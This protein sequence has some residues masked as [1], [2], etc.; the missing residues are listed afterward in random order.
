MEHASREGEDSIRTLAGDLPQ[1]IGRRV[2]IQGWMHNLRKM[3]AVNFLTLR[4][5]SGMAQV[6]LEQEELEALSGLQMETV[7][8]IDGTVR[9]E[10]RA[11][12]G[13]ELAGS[14]IQILAPVTD[15][16]PFEINK[17]V[18]KPSLD[19]FLNN[20]PV[21]LRFPKRRSVFRVYADLIAGFRE[22]LIPRGF[23]EIHTPKLAGS[24]TEGGANVFA[25]E[26]FGKQAYLA[27]SPQLYKQIMV[28]VFER[29]F[30]IGPVFRAEEHYTV[31]HLNE[32]NSLDVEV[33]FIEGQ[34][35]IMDLLI[36]VVECMVL[37]AFERHPE[38]AASLELIRPRFGDVPRI[39]FREAQRLILER[40]GVDQSTEPDLSPQDER[41]IGEWA[42]ETHDTDFV[43]VTHYP[44]AKRA[45]YT[46]PDPTDPA[47]SLSFDLLYKGQ[48]LVSGSQRINRYDQLVQ[49]MRDRNIDPEPFAGYLQAF[50]FGMPPEG[51]F[52]IGS[53]RLLMRLTGAENLRETTL[54]PRD[55][56]R[57]TP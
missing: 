36:E 15:V 9:A 18:L 34:D 31:R 44:T 30:E 37:A 55:V 8:S 1:N 42:S 27:Q 6:F 17:K 14:T 2:V 39:T 28:G 38:D 46:M 25:M 56:N 7:L 43:F 10:E 32:F 49:A 12:G 5:R 29:V 24:A 52:A 50:R 45:F 16:L 57:L 33:G 19:V 22:Y 3:G 40:H 20:A 47:H 48:E 51:G 13:V 41:W 35:E 11:P 54:F 23:V 26:Y 21:G 4:D 53:E